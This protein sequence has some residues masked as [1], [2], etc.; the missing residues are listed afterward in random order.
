MVD[1]KEVEASR[2]LMDDHDAALY[3]DVSKIVSTRF[4]P[5]SWGNDR[6][7]LDKGAWDIEMIIEQTAKNKST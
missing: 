6:S 4:L 7:P 3:K 2:V 1:R 5:V